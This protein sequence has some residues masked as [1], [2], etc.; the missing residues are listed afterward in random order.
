MRMECGYV[1]SLGAMNITVRF[2]RRLTKAEQELF[3]RRLFQA[4]SKTLDDLQSSLPTVE[5][6]RDTSVNAPC[7]TSDGTLAPWTSAT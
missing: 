4:F 3:G 1:A 2:G 5:S 7:G 6:G